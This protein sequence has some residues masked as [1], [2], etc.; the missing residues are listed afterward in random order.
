MSVSGM[1]PLTSQSNVY[2]LSAI[3]LERLSVILIAVGR[4][5]DKSILFFVI[6]YGILVFQVFSV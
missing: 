1:D 3:Y 6:M 2:S 4:T 5:V